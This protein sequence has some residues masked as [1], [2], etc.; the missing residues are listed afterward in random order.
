MQ[1]EIV[2]GEAF[3][4]IMIRRPDGRAV[5]TR[6]PKKGPVPHD[7]IHH[8]VEQEL[9]LTRGFWGMVASGIPPE[10]VQERAKAGGH[11]S[12]T[13]RETP[14]ADIVELIQ[15]ERLVECFE[16]E[17]WSELGDAATLRSVAQAACDHS[18]V[19]MPPLPDT[20]IAAIRARVQALKTEW[21]ALAVGQ[22]LTLDWPA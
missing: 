11:A 4:R 17:I 8:I 14:A 22:S 2:K 21:L 5:E 6:F 7:A 18:F 3:D 13:R 20:A 12:A 9:G 10:Q 19:A 16:A 15:A 1:V